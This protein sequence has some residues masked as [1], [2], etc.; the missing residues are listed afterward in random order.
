MKTLKYYLPAILWILLI[1]FLCTLPSKDVPKVSWFGKLPVDKIV[2][3]CLWGGTVFFLCIGY[4]R[5]NKHIS[6]LTMAVMALL[7]ACYGLAI[8]LVQKFL[9]SS[10]SFE[11]DDL[12]A[13]SLGAFAGIWVFKLF[14]KW[15]IKS[16]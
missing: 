16:R 6:A 12:L 15:F 11:W 7:A 5:Q 8:E 14:R 9:T 4:F 3:F 13:D 2:H 10:R 1:L